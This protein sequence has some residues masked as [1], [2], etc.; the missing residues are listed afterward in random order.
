MRLYS[1]SGARVDGALSLQIAAE[2]PR[3]HE[4]LGPTPERSSRFRFLRTS[5]FGQ[6][7]NDSRSRRAPRRPRGCED[8]RGQRFERLWI[9]CHASPQSQR[10]ALYGTHDPDS[11]AAS[12]GI[13]RPVQS[14]PTPPGLRS[15]TGPAVPGERVSADSLSTG[16]PI[17]AGRAGHLNA[18]TGGKSRFGWN[19]ACRTSGLLTR[20]APSRR[21]AYSRRLGPAAV[22]ARDCLGT[23]CCAERPGC[24]QMM[25]SRWRCQ[26][27]KISSASGATPRSADQACGIRY[28]RSPEAGLLSS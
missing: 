8:D 2:V 15:S 9:S 28:P 10:R 11:D 17:T 18:R 6:S 25:L 7:V 14:L 19:D 24:F 13:R 20:S 5:A 4:I 22:A 1:A 3:P 12:S 27:G 16:T 21:R 26:S 23:R